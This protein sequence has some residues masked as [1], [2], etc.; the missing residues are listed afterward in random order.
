MF[1]YCRE[2]D[3]TLP[4]D[5]TEN[6]RTIPSYNQRITHELYNNNKKTKWLFHKNHVS[7]DFP[8][9]WKIQTITLLKIINF[10]HSVFQ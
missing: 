1:M 7:T 5:D 8:S 9:F 2:L 6:D 10:Q 4:E 3:I